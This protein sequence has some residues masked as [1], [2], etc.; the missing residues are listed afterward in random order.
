MSSYY[1]AFCVV[2]MHANFAAIY[3]T[4][5]TAFVGKQQLSILGRIKQSLLKYGT[6]YFV[7]KTHYP[8]G[9][10]QEAVDLVPPFDGCGHFE[11]YVGG[12]VILIAKL[13][14]VCGTV[15]E[16]HI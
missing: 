12:F 11:K 7:I 5:A 2:G 6:V 1:F 8:H 14:E 9:V 10:F 3:P 4:Y 16:R 15:T 13:P